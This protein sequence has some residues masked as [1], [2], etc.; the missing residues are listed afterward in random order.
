[1]IRSPRQAPAGAFARPVTSATAAP[2]MAMITPTLLRISSASTPSAAPTSMVING[3]VESA[4]EPR[5][6]VVWRNARL[7]STMKNAKYMTPSAATPSQSRP[8]GHLIRSANAIGSSSRNPTPNR[9]TPSVSGSLEPIANR[10]VPPATPPNALEAIAAST[11]TYSLREA[12]M[13]GQQRRATIGGQQT[14]LVGLAARSRIQSPSER[15]I[16]VLPCRHLH[17]LA[18]QHR[19]RLGDAGARGARHDHV[20]DIA[21]FG[22]G[23]G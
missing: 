14:D 17:A 22:G 2:A 21:A 8:R 15:K 13:R 16:I 4:S 12:R 18:P 23:E 7:N 10:V 6:A 19:K 1:M 9:N 20:V 5:A 3:K 11:P